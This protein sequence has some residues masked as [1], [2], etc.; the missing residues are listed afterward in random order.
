ML[1]FDTPKTCQG[2]TW[3]NVSNIWSKGHIHV[4]THC[5]SHTVTFFF[6]LWWA[7]NISGAYDALTQVTRQTLTGWLQIWCPRYSGPLQGPPVEHYCDTQGIATCLAHSSSSD[8]PP[9]QNTAEESD[10]ITSVLSLI[11]TVPT[12]VQPLWWR[13]WYTYMYMST[14]VPA[15][16]VVPFQKRNT[17]FVHVSSIYRDTCISCH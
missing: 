15:L 13:H 14:K 3:T 5:M 4:K 17:K 11:T 6:L 16:V 2:K 7:T 10:D 1:Q 8:M 9:D 12:A